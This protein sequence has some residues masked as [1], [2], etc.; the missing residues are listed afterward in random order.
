MNCFTYGFFCLYPNVPFC[1]MLFWREM[2]N[3]IKKLAVQ[4]TPKIYK[5]DVDTCA[6]SHDNLDK[7]DGYI[8]DGFQA[9]SGMNCP[10]N[11]FFSYNVPM[12]TLP[13]LCQCSMPLVS[14][15][16]EALYSIGALNCEAL[17]FWRV[18]HYW[19]LSILILR[20]FSFEFQLLLQEPEAINSYYCWTH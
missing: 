7:N 15:E 12:V 2:V 14:Q 20:M 4:G 1:F 10:S 5:I 18:L 3:F 16:Q 6:I 17:G 9:H 11:Y 8:A 19:F 13:T